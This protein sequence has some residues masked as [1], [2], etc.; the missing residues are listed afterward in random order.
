M[1]RIK[2]N[3]HRKISGFSL[4]E[5]LVGV[6]I[7][8]VGVVGVLELQKKFITSGNQVN[9]RAIA[10]QLVREKFDAIKAV[11]DF[12]LITASSS[13][14]DKSNYNFK[15]SATPTDY[16]YDDSAKDWSDTSSSSNKLGGKSVNVIV[17]WTDINGNTQSVSQSQV[18][19]KVSL[20]DSD[21]GTNEIGDKTRPK[22][23]FEAN[24]T[25]E[26]PP[27][28]L[29]DKT[30]DFDGVGNSKETSKPIPTVYG[31]E[32]NNVI[33]SI[34]AW[35]V[36]QPLK[37]Y[38]FE[39]QVGYGYS[40]T[41]S[42]EILFFYDSQGVGIYDPYFTPKDQEIHS[43]LLITSYKPIQKITLRAKLNYGIQ[44]TVQNPYP[45]EV[46]VGNFET[47][48]FYKADFNYTEING[49]IEYAVTNNFGIN[50]NY[51]YQETFFY[52]RDNFNLGL[53]FT[54]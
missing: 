21:S 4:V 54:F 31:F 27:I 3:I 1:K 13:T 26:S 2:S 47:G 40:Y 43:A 19:S 35:I 48:G 32:D 24:Q 50:A 42:E 52:K 5:V 51:I 44:A 7:A 30:I 17:T 36:S 8:A 39:F 23:P 45:I 53:N 12:T 34:G 20:H 6:A 33:T 10:M 15:R 29:I 41:D 11:D 14:V 22:V 16:Y 25:P 46:T 38:Q 9:A 28:E 49:S 37:L 18:F